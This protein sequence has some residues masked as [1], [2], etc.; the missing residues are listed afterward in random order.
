MVPSPG[1]RIGVSIPRLLFHSKGSLRQNGTKPGW[2]VF[3]DVIDL[4]SVL[5]RAA[6]AVL[7]WFVLQ[8]LHPTALTT[9][10]LSAL[11]LQDSKYEEV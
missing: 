7:I 6:R 5:T 1:S 4:V 11:F 2:D 9:T 8:D 3:A 10:F